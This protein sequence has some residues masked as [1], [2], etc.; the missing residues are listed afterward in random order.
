M[1]AAVDYGR[2]EAKAAARERFRGLWAR[3]SWW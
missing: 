3:T 1:D 2:S